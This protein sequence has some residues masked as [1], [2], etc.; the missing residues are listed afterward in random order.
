MKSQEELLLKKEL[1]RQLEL[2][3]KAIKVLQQSYASC[4]L[5]GVKDN[6]ELSEMVVFEALTSRFARATDLFTQKI[7]RLIDELELEEQGSIIDRINR[8]EK[9]GLIDSAELFKDVKRLRNRIAHDYAEE[10]ISD[11]FRDVFEHSPVL[12]KSVTH[13]EEYVKK[14]NLESNKEN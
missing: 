3:R 12:M 5:L 2:F 4:S 10:D 1:Q 6:Y 8:A 7:I 9:R 14:F 11:I 13:L